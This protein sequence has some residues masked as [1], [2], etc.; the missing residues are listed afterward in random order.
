[1][2]EMDHAYDVERLVV[3]DDRRVVPDGTVVTCLEYEEALNVARE[4]YD[5]YCVAGCVIWRVPYDRT[6]HLHLKGEV[7]RLAFVGRKDVFWS[8]YH[9]ALVVETIEL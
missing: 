7:D 4:L 3:R 5:E 8:P 1:M 6:L 2:T 9:K